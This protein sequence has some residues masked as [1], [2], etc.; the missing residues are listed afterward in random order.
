MQFGMIFSLIFAVI[1]VIFAVQNTAVVSLYFFLWHFEVPLAIL[2]IVALTIGAIFASL[3]T[4]PGWF[5]WKRSDKAHKK[6]LS[7]L[8]DSLSKYRADLID[9]QNKNKD[10]RQK[11][12]ELEDVKMQLEAA[13]VGADREI[14][15]MA[16]VL[17][18]A[19]VSADEANQ[20]RKEAI[21]ARDELNRA[22]NAMEEKMKLREQEAEL[23][24]TVITAQAEKAAE[25]ITL[26]TLAGAANDAQPDDEGSD[27]VELVPVDDED[28]DETET[29]DENE[30]V[31]EAAEPVEEEK[32]SRFNFW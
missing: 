13:Q 25:P 19:Q 11:I 31:D 29:A 27:L 6:E 30:A 2:L 1:A 10:L 28:K 23:M 24:R 7:G 8:E 32:K 21:E 26:D 12:L 9:T 4:F 5:K 22:L 15:D 14:K 17:S 16:D 18:Q 3:F 20:A